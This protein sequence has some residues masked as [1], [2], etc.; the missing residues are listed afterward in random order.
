MYE[1]HASVE[2]RDMVRSAIISEVLHVR[3][4]LTLRVKV[5]L[6]LS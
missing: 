5:R 6:T 1:E 4:R 2:D 3:L